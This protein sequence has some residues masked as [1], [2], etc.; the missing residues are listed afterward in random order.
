MIVSL[1]IGALCCW[2]VTHLLNA[3]DGP[4]EILARFRRLAGDGFLG[5]LLDC[6]YCLSLWVAAPFAVLLGTAWREGVLLW[7]S[8][9]AAAIL[10]E[11]T[12]SR[13]PMTPLVREEIDDELLRE[14]TSGR[15]RNAER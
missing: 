14:S 15:E 3:E 4:G 7:L 8:I 13:D 6:F 12:T 9:S 2:R 11:R 1:L 10:L 5:Q